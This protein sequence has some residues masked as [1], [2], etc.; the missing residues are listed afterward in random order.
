MIALQHRL[1]AHRRD[2]TAAGL[3]RCDGE[4][5]GSK[6]A[7]ASAESGER[8]SRGAEGRSPREQE[9]YRYS[10]VFL[11]WEGGVL[12]PKFLPLVMAQQCVTRFFLFGVGVVGLRPSAFRPTLKLVCAFVWSGFCRSL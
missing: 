6:V 5:G 4:S 10:G 1:A 3:R 12:I 8:L 11:V 2:L 7:S 9:L